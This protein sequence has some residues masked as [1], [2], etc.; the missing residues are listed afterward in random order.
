MTQKHI[1]RRYGGWVENEL[2][3]NRN[4]SRS[5]FAMMKFRGK[6]L[7]RLLIFPFRISIEY[8]MPTLLKYTKGSFY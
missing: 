1:E 7:W 5:I 4:T 8:F 3:H 6:Y 2:V